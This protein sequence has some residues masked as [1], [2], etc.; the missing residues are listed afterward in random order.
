MMKIIHEMISQTT[1]MGGI[2]PYGVLT[3]SALLLE[4]YLLFWQL[5]ASLIVILVIGLGIKALY[6]RER[7]KKE[8]YANALERIDASSFPSIHSARITALAIIFSLFFNKTLFTALLII[9]AVCVF[10]SRIYLKKHR[11]IDI[12]GGAI[13][14][15][16]VSYFA[17]LIF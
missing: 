6:F 15:A 11:F 4:E 3:A 9:L 8:K 14:G 10:Y 13:L 1:H 17:R 16:A 5:L 7:P 2:I 12:I